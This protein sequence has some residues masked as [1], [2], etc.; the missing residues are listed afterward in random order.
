MSYNIDNEKFEIAHEAF[1]LHML[2]QSRGIPFVNF[3]HPFL[4]DNEISYKSKI[5]YDAKLVLSLNDWK[6]WRKIP[7]NIILTTK[8]ACKPAI[9]KNLLEHRY[10]SKSYSE[11]ALYKVTRPEQIRGLEDNLYDFF[12][13]GPSTPTE[14]GVRFD[15]FALY[16]RENHLG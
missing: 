12:L 1:K 8:E 15:S 9:S 14:F 4:F 7:G 11:A 13:G 10:G 16:L 2:H 3:Y 6:Q 5:Y